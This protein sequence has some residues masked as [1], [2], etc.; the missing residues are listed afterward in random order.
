MDDKF[1]KNRLDLAYK[2]QLHYLNAVLLLGTVGI[3]SFIGTFIWKRE[4]LFQ[5]LI[6]SVSILLIIYFWHHK[7]DNNLKGISN[8]IKDLSLCFRF[9]KS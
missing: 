1:E 9:C 3:L 6:I 2:R 5:G 7:I 8:E 4:L